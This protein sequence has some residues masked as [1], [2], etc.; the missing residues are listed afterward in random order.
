VF[1]TRLHRQ[2][3]ISERRWTSP[4]QRKLLELPTPPK[5]LKEWYDW[6]SWLDNNFRRMQRI[7]KRGQ[8]TPN[9]GNRK[10]KEEPWRR[11]NFQRK[12]PNVMDVDIITTTMNAMTVE[13]QEKFMREGLCFWCRKPGH[14]SWDCPMKKGNF[15]I[16]P[17]PST[18]TT[19][20]IPPKNMKGAELV[21]H[22]RSLTTGLD[23]EEMKEFMDLAEET[24]F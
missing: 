3:I 22:I 4:L 5:N 24:G 20:P 19:T 7:L 14:I 10:G 23:K 16:L 9:T 6:A 17:R 18:T 1:Q 2:S 13:E 8:M 15:Q 21:A 11:W 12:D